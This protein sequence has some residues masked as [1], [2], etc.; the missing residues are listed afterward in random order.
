MILSNIRIKAQQATSDTF[1]F[2][3]HHRG[4][5]T[6]KQLLTLFGFADI[7]K[8]RSVTWV[9][10]YFILAFMFLS[11]LTILFITNNCNCNYKSYIPYR[12]KFL[13]L[14]SKSFL[15]K[16]LHSATIFLIVH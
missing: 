16:F 4:E 7:T 1:R 11:F 9:E 8:A 15:L 3:G 12:F 10:T 14:K 6:N 13:C 5:T 2:C